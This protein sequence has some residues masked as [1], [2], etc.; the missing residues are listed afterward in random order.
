MTARAIRIVPS[1]E[2]GYDLVAEGLAA[3]GLTRHDAP[4]SESERVPNEEIWL[5]SDERSAV[6]W[7]E[8]DLIGVS[9]IAVRGTDVIPLSERIRSK[10]PTDDVAQLRSRA[11]VDRGPDALIDT[12]YRTAVVA[13]SGYDPEAFS[14]LRWGLNDPDSLVRRVAL[15]AISITGWPEF[16]GLLDE[17]SANDPVDE[18]RDQAERVRDLLQSS[19]GNGGV[20]Q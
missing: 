9:Y 5:S 11:M 10:L 18:V 17:V 14:L 19:T 6:H 7:I 13:D 4:S 20:S 16:T 3:L 12:L 2:V 1:P 15:L 8:D